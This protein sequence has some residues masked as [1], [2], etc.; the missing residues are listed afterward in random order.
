MAK[1]VNSGEIL[2]ENMSDE[3]FNYIF[4]GTGD[5]EI[6]AKSAK[7]TIEKLEEIRNEFLYF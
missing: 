6:I 7:I 1:F 2:A 3:F 4:Y 5:S